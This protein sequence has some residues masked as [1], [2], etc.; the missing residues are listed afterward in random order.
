MPSSIQR[1]DF[2]TS[3]AQVVASPCAAQASG[4][5]AVAP[6]GA[7]EPVL[8][9]PMLPAPQAQSQGGQGAPGVHA[10]QAQ[11]Q[12]TP[13]PAAAAVLLPPHDPAPQS[14]LHGGQ[15]SPGAHAGQVQV[16]VP[17][18]PPPPGA[19]FEQSHSTAGQS[20]FAGHAIGCTQVQPPPEASRARQ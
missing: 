10:G 12:V 16:H 20:A 5:S 6:P 11:V 14:Q 13:L 3:A 18:P 7:S 9:T 4:M 8:L 1:Q 17:P 15:A 2:A 19:G